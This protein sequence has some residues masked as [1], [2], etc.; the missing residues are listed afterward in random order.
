[1]K[2]GENKKLIKAKVGIILDQPFFAT[3]MMRKNFI[4]DPSIKTACTN[5]K[6]IKYNPNYFDGLSNDELQ[7]VICHELLHGTLLHHLRREGRDLKKW[8]EACDY[9]LNPILKDG[10]ISLPKGALI[11]SM[12]SGHS[13][14]DIYKLLPS[15]NDNG[16]GDGNGNTEGEGQD[17]PGG[18]GDVE[19][20]PVKDESEM[21]QAEAEAK[22]ELAQAIQ[23]A[24]QQGK[25][26]G[27]LERLVQ[28][29]LE[30]KVEWKEVLARFLCEIAKNDYSFSKPNTRYLSTGFIMPS[31]YNTEFGEV[32]LMVDTSGSIDEAQLN[33]FAGEMQDIANNFSTPIKVLY[34]DTEVAGEQD[35]EPDE[36]I[37]LK[38]Q[39]GGGTD[40]VPG[41]EWLAKNGIIPKAVVYFTDGYCDSFPEDPEFPVLW[42]VTSG[43]D[44]EPPF[45]ETVKID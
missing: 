8:N 18:M 38:P 31:L 13:A 14:E 25:L 11:N 24:K 7:G 44:F 4:A 2:K 28:E 33:E 43:R 15:G 35:I 27:A 32:V 3:L 39:G 45:G 21:M 40:F 36:V 5:G 10:N 1:M 22:Q 34:V 37:D 23:I 41:F 26:P 29:I 20:A 6:D 30:P 12:F 17:Q 16:G 9:A 42:A 19:D